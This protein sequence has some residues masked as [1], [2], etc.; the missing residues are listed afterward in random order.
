MDKGSQTDNETAEDIVDVSSRMPS[1]NNHQ[2]VHNPSM[3]SSILSATPTASPQSSSQAVVTHLISTETLIH[4]TS[5]EWSPPLSSLSFSSILV[6][7]NQKCQQAVSLAV[8]P[9]SRFIVPVGQLPDQGLERTATVTVHPPWTPGELH[10][11]V[12]EFPDIREEPEKF[13]RELEIVIICFNP[14]WADL[15]QFMCAVL[16]FEVSSNL[17]KEAEWPA[18]NPGTGPALTQAFNRLTEAVLKVCPKKINWDKIFSSKQKEGEAPTDYMDRLK[19][20]FERYSGLGVPEQVASV[21]IANCFILGLWPKVRERLQS[22]IGENMPLN[23]LVI[24][25][26]KFVAE[27]KRKKE[28]A[29]TKLRDLQIQYY[30]SQTRGY[31]QNEGGER[32][33]GVADSMTCHY[34]GREGHWK[35]ECPD[36]P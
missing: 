6:P 10:K 35:N 1:P 13:K 4:E 20:L 11:I 15:N 23:R 36:R 33:L 22:K 31:I 17:K 7:G 8:P 32:Y 3:E 24:I 12:R 27:E 30:K 21:L 34:C 16:P 19:Q 14:T 28:M 29:E 5:E 2:P 26:E 25:A 9:R 18:Q